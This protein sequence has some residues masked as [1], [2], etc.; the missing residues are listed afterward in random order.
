MKEQT[1]QRIVDEGVLAVLRGPSEDL[2]LKMVEALL[3]GGVKGI[4]I[5]FT[6]PNALAVIET[7]AN[8]FHGDILLGVGTV[9]KIDQ[10]M[11]AKNAG[12]QFLVS[13]HTDKKLLKSMV[14]TKLP[15][16]AGA[17][18]PSEVVAALKYGADIVKIFPGSLV[19]PTYI[20]ALRGPYPDLRAM[21][22]GGVNKE[23]IKDWFAAGAIAVGAGS[24]LCPKSW[25]LEGRFEEITQNA[26]EYREIIDNARSVKQQKVIVK[27]G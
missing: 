24:N 9:T 21:P 6:T 20:K 4:E 17:L 8:Q 10:S 22:T 5:T 11:A 7:L 12:A 15:V 2:T 26:R 16:I 14:K 1:I 23:N 3:K 13:P 25:A 19:G 27:K 18:T